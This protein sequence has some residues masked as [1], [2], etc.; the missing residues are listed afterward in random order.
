MIDFRAGFDAY[1]A[2]TEKKWKH[3]RSKSVGASEAFGCMRAVWFKKNGTEPDPDYEQSWGALRRGDLIENHF[4]EPAVRWYLEN[5]FPNTRLV[6]GGQR[7]KTL[8]DTKNNLSA[9]PDG[10][11]IG[12]D[13]D[14]LAEYG[15]PSLGGTGCFNLEIKSIDP[16]VNLKEEKAV[17]RGQTIVQM[18]LTREKT[19][20]KPNY[21]VIIYIDASFFDDIDVFV[22]PFDQK[23]YDIAKQRAREVFTITNPAEIM[24]EGKYENGCGYCQFKRACARVSG[25]AIPEEGEMN[26]D[27]APSPLMQEFQ[28]LVLDERTASQES[29]YWEAKHKLASEKLKQ[30]FVDTGVRRAEVPGVVKA[31][32]SW[33]KGRT[34]YDYKA[35]LADGLDLTPYTRESE[36]HSRL[37]ITEKGPKKA[38][39][40]EE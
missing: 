5:H 38:E 16:R 20:Y 1:V 36:G 2:A 9:T 26:A 24:A 10:L 14:A 28:S 27:T 11:V 22:I 29:K 30:W 12:A 3:D 33:V 34:S 4:V 19:S 18:G 21:A 32:I 39:A 23:T 37:F 7:Q 13:D 35:M 31:S 15:V 6:Y 25:N 17:H 40:E 8:I